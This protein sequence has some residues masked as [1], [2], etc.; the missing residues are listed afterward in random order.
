MTLSDTSWAR[1]GDGVSISIGVVF[2]TDVTRQHAH[3]HALNRVLR[4]FGVSPRVPGESALIDGLKSPLANAIAWDM[5]RRGFKRRGFEGM[6]PGWLGR[7][8]IVRDLCRA[9]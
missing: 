9:A 8:P 6:L 2:Y 7:A 3:L 5:R 4:R 1:P